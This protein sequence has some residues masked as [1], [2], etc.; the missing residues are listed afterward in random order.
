MKIGTIT[1]HWG[2]N[3]GAV[4]Q[5]YALQQHLKTNGYDT[6]IID[7]IP[8]SVKSRQLM[9]A[10][11]HLQMSYLV[12]EFKINRFR[13]NHLLI[14]AATYYDSSELRNGCN[15]YDVYICGSDQIWNEWFV[16]SSEN[17]P[18]LTYYLD[19]V[20]MDKSRIS[21]ATSFGT[22]ELS[23]KVINLIKPELEK[24]SD[25]SV[26]ENSGKKIVQDIGLE[27][28]LV[29]DPTLLLGKESYE[30]LIEDKMVKNDFQL[31]SYILHNNQTTAHTVTEYVFDKYFDKRSDRKYD[32]EP[33]GIIEWLLSIRNARFVVT[34]SFHGLIFSLIFHTPFIVV[35]VENSGMND[36]IATLLD[37]VNL[38]NRIVAEFNQ[39]TV[40]TLFAENINWNEVDE[41]INAMRAASISFL[42]NSLGVHYVE[43]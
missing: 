33:I 20:Q 26:R 18:N 40:D 13:T 24:F 34:N 1:F 36:R 30:R 17:K 10:I 2:T 42:E 14:S 25:I 9:S 19:F 32:Q 5:A 38:N 27:A 29:V 43:K 11:K 7:Y 35:P 39:D 15:Q 31:F 3:Y 37:S 8:R 41:K 16:L 21:Y 4:L 23:P 6:E 12:K 28:R 22:D